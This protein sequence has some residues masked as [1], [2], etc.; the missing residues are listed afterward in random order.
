MK[1]ALLAALA[2]CATGP[3]LASPVDITL[4][5]AY[6]TVTASGAGDFQTQ[7]CSSDPNM[8]ASTLGPDG[9]PVY[10]GV[11]TFTLKDI[12]PVTNE[13]QWWTPGTAAGG[14]VVTSSGTGTIT[15]PFESTS[16]FPPTGPNGN[17]GNDLGGFLTAE[18]TGSFTLAGTSNVTFTLGADDDAFFFVDGNLVTG[19]GGVH[20]D[21]PAPTDTVTLSGGAHNIELFYADRYQTNAA[22]N[23]GL[24]STGITPVPEASTWAMMGLGFAGLG[25][26]GFRARR[27]AISIA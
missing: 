19:L 27:S 1:K 8:V 12:N 24:D 16:M 26:A 6:N 21:T 23:F 22:L 5:G 20:A 18:F 17:V 11:S 14:D 13:I 3:A 9:L 4:T 15:T 2:V 10:T 25:F 7:C